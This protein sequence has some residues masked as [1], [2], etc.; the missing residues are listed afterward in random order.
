MVEGG[1]DWEER[2][3]GHGVG[4]VIEWCLGNHPSGYKQFGIG[5]N[6]VGFRLNAD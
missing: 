4:V 1:K 3:H 2:G 5:F 6:E